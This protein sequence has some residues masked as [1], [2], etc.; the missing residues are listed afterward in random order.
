MSKTGANRIVKADKEESLRIL[1]EGY[2]TLEE[3]L[4]LADE[5]GD[6]ELHIFS[7]G[8]NIEYIEKAAAFFLGN[9]KGKIE[10]VKN[11]EDMTGGNQLKI[12]FD[13]FSRVDHRSKVLFIWDWDKEKSVKGL[14]ET[15][16]TFKFVFDK[17]EESRKPGIENLFAVEKASKFYD[18][19]PKRDDDAVVPILNK[20]RLKRYM[21]SKGTR[22]DFK[23]FEPLFDKIKDILRL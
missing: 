13:F 20:D 3:G 10:V 22:K 4:K 7:E 14:K 23:N 12:L 5:L 15:C 8:N 21:I 6:K 1:T 9:L 11:I 2:A 16:N 17:N 19:K 18:N